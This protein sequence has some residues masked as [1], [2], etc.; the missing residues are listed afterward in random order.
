MEKEHEHNLS[1]L[2]SMLIHG[3]GIKEIIRAAAKV[4]DRPIILTTS[5]YKVIAMYD[6]GI[7]FDDDVW[8]AAKTYGYCSASSIRAFQNQG[9]TEKVVNS[10][11]AILLDT[12]LAKEIPRILQKV[13][14]RGEIIAYLGV[15]IVDRSMQENE[16][17]LVDTLTDIL[18]VEL[19]NYPEYMHS[20]NVIYESILVDLIEGRLTE[21]SILKERMQSALWNPGLL[22]RCIYIAF[23]E[24]ENHAHNS[25]Y[26]IQEFNRHAAIKT[27]LV[28]SGLFLLCSYQTSES[29]EG[30][31][32]YIEEKSEEFQMYGCISDEFQ[33]LL[34]L[35]EHFQRVRQGNLLIRKLQIPKAYCYYND[36]LP[37][38]LIDQI[39]RRTLQEYTNTAYRSLKEYDRKRGT[40]Y[41]ET[42][43]TYIECGNQASET[44]SRMFIH[45]NS[46]SHRLEKI[47]KIAEIDLR[48]GKMLHDIYLFHMIQKVLGS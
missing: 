44:A 6:N 20:T 23:R 29:W 18:S 8:Q 43:I 15:F 32:K 30:V 13:Q 36:L 2:T 46:M 16:L 47:S 21:E 39:D 1:M 37:C 11:G 5:S 28:E 34:E 40:N 26:F 25:A 38:L 3:N 31:L 24:G 48:D 41:L 33:N 27:I 19:R 10:A 22:F 45:R 12:G 4:L 7:V 9:I 17:Q 35:K 14:I 42:L